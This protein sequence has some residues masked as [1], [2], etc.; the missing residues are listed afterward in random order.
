MKHKYKP[1]NEQV[2]VITGASSGIGLATARR[3]AKRGAKLVLASRNEEVL[4]QV[5]DE[6]VEQGGQAIYVVADVGRKEQV[7]AIAA[8]A[9]EHFGGFDTWVNNAGV[10]IFSRLDDLPED[11]H[12]RLFDTNYWGVVH[13]SEAAVQHLR[14]RPDGGTI[15]NVASINAEMPV[16][17]LGAYSASKAAVKAYSEALRME[18][19]HEDLPIKVTVLK[20]YGIATPISDHGRSHMG[21]RGKVMPPL[22]DV[23]IVATAILAAAQRPVRNLTVG[24]T[25]KMSELGWAVAPSLFDR[26]IA[27]ALPRAQSS[28]KP[29]LQKDNL[30]EAGDDGQVYLEGKRAGIPIS[31]YTQ[32]RSHRVLEAGLG[33]GVVAVASL[34]LARRFVSR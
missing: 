5:C 1:L 27:W 34:L 8:R 11:E 29:P 33:L 31:P 2:V 10:V 14:N 15:I 28:D 17:I 6:I 7:D 30:F 12:R 21:H 20:P 4:K 26:V 13:G 24:E 32:I 23:E 22:Y 19:I 3:A 9:I 16:P 18:L 25:G